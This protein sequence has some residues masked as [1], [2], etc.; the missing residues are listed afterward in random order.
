M[1]TDDPSDRYTVR[2]EARDTVLHCPEMT[3]RQPCTVRVEAGA[4]LHVHVGGDASARSAITAPR[5]RLTLTVE[6]RSHGLL[7][8][9]AAL[10]TLGGGVLIA[11]VA[12]GLEGFVW[13][14]FLGSPSVIAGIVLS[15][16]DVFISHA[17][18]VPSPS[19]LPSSS[20]LPAPI[21]G[22]AATV[23]LNAPP[24]RF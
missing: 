1:A 15:L 4:R 12:S 6:R 19:G 23:L 10:I 9:G 22:P 20:I 3:L 14:V 21:E 8:G 2:L 13:A 5:G 11:S 24:L 17:R 7:V 18:L 16:V